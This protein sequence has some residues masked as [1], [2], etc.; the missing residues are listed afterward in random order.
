[1]ATDKDYV[2][3]RSYFDTIGI[4]RKK[5]DS[6]LKEYK[7]D[8]FDANADF[9]YD[10]EFDYN[11]YDWGNYVNTQS[12]IIHHDTL[13]NLEIKDNTLK[14][15][16]ENKS[17]FVNTTTI[18]VNNNSNTVTINSESITVSNT[19]VIN[20][21]HIQATFGTNVYSVNSE[22]LYLKGPEANVLIRP[23]NAA[24]VAT[25]SLLSAN[26]SWTSIA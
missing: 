17:I 26:G 9:A 1:M 22:G 19:I 11:S 5:T 25:G 4:A 7:D 18:V 13:G 16:F 14:I 12:I 21:T 10:D 3:N 15:V 23:P 2:N 20:T 6:V 8:V 24:Q